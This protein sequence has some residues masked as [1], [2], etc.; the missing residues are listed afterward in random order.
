MKRNYLFF[1]LALLL[2]STLVLA[3][4]GGDTTTDPATDAPATDEP[5]VDETDEP[6]EEETTE[7][8]T[9]EAAAPSDSLNQ[10]IVGTTTEPTGD[11]AAPLWQNNATD[12]DITN[13][14]LAGYSLVVSNPGGEIFIDET[15]VEEHEVTTNDDGS[16]THRWVIKPGKT[17]SD[18]TEITAKHYVAQTLLFSHPV[19]TELLAKPT[20]G[21]FYVGYGEYVD[22]TNNVFSGVRLLGDYEFSYTIDPEYVP[23][24]FELSFA[25]SS[26]IPLSWWV[27]AEDIDIAD[28]G[29]GAYFTK[30][31][32]AEANGDAINAARNSTERVVSGPYNVVSYDEG[33][34]MA[35]LAINP[36]YQGDYQGNKPQI[37]TI[38]Y[39]KVASETSMDELRTGAV[40]LLDNIMEGDPI[41]QGFALIDETGEDFSYVSYPRSGYGKIHF[42]CDFGPTEHAE[43]RHAIAHLLDRN[44]FARAFTGGYGTV[45]HGPY[46]E[47]QWTYQDSRQDLNE[48]LNTY[49]YSKED[50]ERLVIEAGYTFDANGGEWNGTGLRHKEVDGAYEPLLIRWTSS[51]N[52]AVSDLL[53]TQLANNPDLAAIGMEIQQDVMTFQELLNYIYRDGSQGDKYGV[54]TYHMANFAS[55]FPLTY[56]PTREFSQDPQDI[57][58]GYNTNFLLDDQLEEISKNYWRVSPEDRDAFREGWVDYIVRWNELLP[59]LP[60]YSNEIHHFFNSKLVGYEPSPY[61]GVGAAL[62]LSHVE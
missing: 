57:K 41:N 28:D 29:E 39:K 54:P 5:V 52:N 45:V 27:G 14:L 60:L 44:E 51:E 40:D 12:N 36:E 10:I 62:I 23:S 15:V 24:F 4:C 34:K 46:G 33:T 58:Q 35:E 11:F 59:D 38:I 26:P 3:G 19:M 37:E 17:F 31:P 6:E 43:V 9:T 20:F 25:S 61:Y 55:N 7:E 50:A 53:V 22:G 42:V 47:A 8:E 2:V 21:Q 48:K 49:A 32:T 13:N 30:E 1:L 18:G 56:V 16:N